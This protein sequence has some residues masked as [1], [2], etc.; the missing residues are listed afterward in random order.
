MV[1]IRVFS[2]VVQLF[3]LLKNHQFYFILNFRIINLS[4]LIIL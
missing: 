1:G 4:I 2:N 3:E